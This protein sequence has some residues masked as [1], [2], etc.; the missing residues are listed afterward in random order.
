MQE[1]SKKIQAEIN[2]G[3]EMVS[4]FSIKGDFSKTSP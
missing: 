2:L 4:V 1:K 3:F